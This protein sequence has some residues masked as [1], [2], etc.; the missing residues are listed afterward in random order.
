MSHRTLVVIA[1]AY[2]Y[3]MPQAAERAL[4]VLKTT[5]G[6][7]FTPGKVWRSNPQQQR[8]FNTF[9]L[10]TDARQVLLS[11]VLGGC[12][13]KVAKIVAISIGALQRLVSLQTVGGVSDRSNQQA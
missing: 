8:A 5:D 4:L 7:A 2:A 6:T 12:K 1:I 10:S 9:I 11:P 3:P 13:T